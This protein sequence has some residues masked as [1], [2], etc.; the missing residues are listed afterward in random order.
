MKK[1]LLIP[2][3]L[4]LFLSGCVT[5]VEVDGVRY[6]ALSESQKARLVAVCREALKKNYH[7][8]IITRKE[9][10]FCR[11]NAPVIKIRYR[12]DYF[13]SAWVSWY[14]P[15]RL[16]EFLFEE[17]LTAEQPLCAFS[18]GHIPESDRRILPDK[19]VRGR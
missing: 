14:T 9:Y 15:G 13:G 11:T 19:S 16:L 7:K 3:L 10:E 12:G 2:I 17:D 1:F 8:K 5:Y 18:V 6:A 4:L